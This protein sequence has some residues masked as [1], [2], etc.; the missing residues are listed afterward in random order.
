[1]EY[2]LILFVN[3]ILYFRTIW[4]GYVSDDLAKVDCARPTWWLK[5]LVKEIRA[6]NHL[7]P[8]LAHLVSMAIHTANCLLIYKGFGSNTVSLVASLLF[9]INPANLSGA[10][11]ISGRGYAIN[12]LIMLLMWSFKAWSPLFYFPFSWV[13]SVYPFSW[14]MFAYDSHWYLSLLVIPALYIYILKHKKAL[15]FRKSLTNEYMKELSVWKLVVFIKTITYYFFF[16]LFPYRIGM[17]HNFMFTYGLQ[18]DDIKHWRSLDKWF[19]GG[20]ALGLAVIYAI[21]TNFMGLGLGLLWFFLGIFVWSNIYMA[22]QPIA[23]RYAY[24]ANAGLMY[25][26]AI[27]IWDKP[28][29]LAVVMTFYIT[30][31]LLHINAYKTDDLFLEYNL[32]DFNFPNHPFVWTLKGDKERALRRPFQA[33]ESWGK[34]LKY[35]PHDTRLNFY[36]AKTLVELGFFKEAEYHINMVKKYPIYDIPNGITTIGI[37]GLEDAIKKGRA[38]DGWENINLRTRTK[39][40]KEL[41]NAPKTATR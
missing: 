2:L 23:D 7:Y 5:D 21:F 32:Y 30:R 37:T 40:G 10:V 31:N 19:W 34:G 8:K 22:N 16:C 39:T 33:L 3:L 6:D 38:K 28:V 13:V 25:V 29:L 11:W 35:R 18:D 12:L 24:L 14:L 1:M 4:F 27:L 15:E 17:Y 36:T 20:L 26:L 9:A 41:T